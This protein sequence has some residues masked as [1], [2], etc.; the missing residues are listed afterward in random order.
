VSVYDISPLSHLT[1]LQELDLHQLQEEQGWLDISPLSS[2]VNL[3]SLGLQ[4]S[5]ADIIQHTPWARLTGL[6]KL[7]LHGSRVGDLRPLGVLTGLKSLELSQTR[8]LRDIGPLS[9]LTGLQEL[10]LTGSKNVRDLRPILQL[11]GLMR[12][13]LLKKP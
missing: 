9:G 8:E 11:H 3:T 10:V 12:G 6:C 4:G 1:N 5:D 7:D 2:L 13:G